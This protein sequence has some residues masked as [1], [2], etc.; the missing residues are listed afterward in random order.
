MIEALLT[1]AEMARADVLC[2]DRLDALMQAAGRAVAR[3]VRARFAPCPVLALCGPGHNGGDGRIAARLLGQWGWPVEIA[4]PGEAGFAPEAAARAGLVIDALFGAGLSRDLS[5]AIAAVL[6]AARRLVAVDVPSGLDGATGQVRG[7]A[8]QAMLTVTFFRRKPG[9]LLPPGRVLCGELV[10][11]DIG[12]P[13]AL[14]D[15]LRPATFRNTPAL[16]SL[17]APDP[18]AHKYAR[19]HL[20]VLGG[21]TLT[22]AARLVAMAARRAG[23]GLVTIAAQ[24]SA[25]VYRAGAPGVMVSEAPLAEPLADPR[26]A[27]WVCGPGLGPP[28]GSC[29][30]ALLAAGRTVL[31]DA[32]ALTACAG[33]P[34]RLAGAAVLT[35]HDGEFARLFGPVGPDRLAAAR[36]AARQTG[37]VIVLKG[38]AS[39]IAAP[40]GRAA[41][42][43][44]APPSLA[45]AGTGDVLAGIIAALLAQGMARWQAA[46]AGV[47]LHG[48][49]A[50]LAGPALIA[51][52]L[53][54]FL[55]RAFAAAREVPTHPFNPI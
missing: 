17:P 10:L 28:A 4:A 21:A 35:P 9:H 5:P 15:T 54:A 33:H 8:P 31:A 48:W 6:G 14:L 7:F 52:D 25:A 41:I 26:R 13:A 23:A 53:P 24:G 32:D 55:P 44:N 45:S 40:D 39:V 27:V 36:A 34:E 30:A 47:W 37:A 12:M 42:N 51:E 3:A 43:D 22:G 19:G 11:A 38:P 20:T 18:L 49:A 29:L 46:C 1:P 2:A 16:W 50:R